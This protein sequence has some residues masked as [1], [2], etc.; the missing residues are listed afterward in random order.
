MG[1]GS[2]THQNFSAERFLSAI[3]LRAIRQRGY[4]DIAVPG[5]PAFSCRE[6]NRFAARQDFR[7]KLRVFAI[8]KVKEWSVGVA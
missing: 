1:R 8:L 3:P 5:G 4:F 7:L 2:S 6:Q